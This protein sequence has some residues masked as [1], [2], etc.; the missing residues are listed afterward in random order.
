MR[1]PYVTVRSGAMIEFMNP[2][3][4]QIKIEDIAWHLARTCRYNGHMDVWYSNAEHSVMGTKLTNDRELARE[5][6]LH[7]AAEFVF[8]DMASPVKRL[9][10]QYSQMIDKFQAFINMMFF[11]RREFDP[12]LKDL[13]IRLTATEQKYLRK[14]QCQDWENHPFHLNRTEFLCYDW[15]TAYNVYLDYFRNLYPERRDC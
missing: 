5:F 11:G 7:D 14:D 10:P 4:E 3:P 15:E 13:D 1:E 9:V 6:L 12:R 8:G 2:K